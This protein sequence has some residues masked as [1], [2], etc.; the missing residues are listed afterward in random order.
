MANETLTS[1]FSD[2]A[3]AIREKGVTGQMTPLQMPQK[4][5]DIPSGGGSDSKLFDADLELNFAGLTA[6]PDDNIWDGAS[7][8]GKFQNWKN[9]KSVSFPDIVSVGKNG[10]RQMFMQCSSLTTAPALPITTLADYCYSNMFS[11]CESLTTAPELPATTLAKGCY[12]GMFVNCS[13]LTSAPALPATT[14]AEYCYSYMF[15]GCTSLTT[16]PIL[17]A[18]TLATSC[19]YYMFWR[20][21]ALSGAITIPILNTN[22]YIPDSAFNNMF[23]EC[24]NLSKVILDFSTF[25]SIPTLGSVNSINVFNSTS[26]TRFEIHVPSALEDD[27]KTASNWSDWASHIVGV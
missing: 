17:P 10:C 16:A 25:S 5:A 27:W 24:S 8:S 7:V 23:R 15:R 1:V 20:C 2:I 26:D 9:I 14:L 12:S 19:Y 13:S 6:I 3:D 22:T 21:T 4:I 18:T 11:G